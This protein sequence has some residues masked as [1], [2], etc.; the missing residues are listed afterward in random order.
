MKNIVPYIFLK[1]FSLKTKIIH[2]SACRGSAF[3]IFPNPEC[4]IKVQ[5]SFHGPSSLEPTEL[6][7]IT[8]G[9]SNYI[10]KTKINSPLSRWVQRLILHKMD[11]NIILQG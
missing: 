5:I 11:S 4:Q 8:M 1:I 2:I 3:V 10:S 9:G 6:L 7:G